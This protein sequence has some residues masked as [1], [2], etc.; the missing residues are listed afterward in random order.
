MKADKSRRML[1]VFLAAILTIILLAAASEGRAAQISFSA[2]KIIFEFNSSG[3]DLG[4]QV[5]LDGEPWNEIKVVDPF[6]RTI[7]EVETQGRLR[8]FG[9]TELFAESHEPNFADMTKEEI[10]DLFPEG[11]YQF[12]GK[13]TDGK[14]LKATATLTHNIPDGPEI[15]F[16]Q[17]GDV[18][19]RTNTVIRWNPVTSPAGIKIVSYQ[20][21][22]DGGN[23]SRR[24]DVTV[25]G[26][27][28]SV[29][30]PPQFLKAGT[31]YNFEVLA[32]EAGGNQTITEGD[33]F[34]PQP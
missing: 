31:E 29:M 26:T 3:P 12:F 7:V 11:K 13:T 18:V 24:F 17:E 20:I 16:P 23:P 4:I 21:V 27:A 14:S 22:V 15:L 28:T 30:V 6:G 34:V 19:R 5:F 10:L 25:P 9:L 33:P 8:G 1:S 32:I 2:A